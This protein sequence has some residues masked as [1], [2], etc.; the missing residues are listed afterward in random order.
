MDE[1]KQQ[2]I[3]GL[4][5]EWEL[6]I[7][8]GRAVTVEQLC[9]DAP[10]LLPQLREGIR[11]LEATSWI[12][13]DDT[14][15]GEAQETAIGS[16][17]GLPESEMTVEQIAE[18]LQRHNILSPEH[19]LPLKL[20]HVKNGSTG[21]QFVEACVQKSLLNKYQAETVRL[22]HCEHLSMD[23][24]LIL[25]RLGAGGMGV[26]YKA[27]HRLM[28]RVVALKVLLKSALDST[29]KVKRFHREIKTV[30]RIDHPNVVTGY[31]AHEF[32]GTHFLVMELVEG[33]NLAEV[34]R[35][36]GCFP[37]E[38]AVEVVRQ[39]ATGLAEAHR[40]GLVHRDIKPSNI[41]LGDN[42][43]AKLLDLG[44]AT[45]HLFEEQTVERTAR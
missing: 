36:N 13:I 9:G 1:S 14:L 20:E 33:N 40:Q 7:E 5:V 17:D 15:Q 24:Y 21:K 32:N 28:D 25:D 43:V 27:K 37:L 4:L 8:Q 2:Q 44:L 34:V 31:D 41:M 6:A 38:E 45:N 12:L 3:D 23:R 29:E 22:G 42:G 19:V 26:V 30:A 10:H 39:V 11:A 18:A 16:P 35:E